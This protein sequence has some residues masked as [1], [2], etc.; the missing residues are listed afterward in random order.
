MSAANSHAV[1][2]KLPYS[3]PDLHGCKGFLLVTS[4]SSESC[5]LAW[6]YDLPMG[7]VHDTISM[8]KMGD[9]PLLQWDGGKFEL[10]WSH[11]PKNRSHSNMSNISLCGVS[12][13][14]AQ[15]QPELSL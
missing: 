5:G 10:Q 4:Y 2:G 14:S 11:V 3:E 13:V 12:R 6:V 9:G 7:E 8:A 1:L 15:L